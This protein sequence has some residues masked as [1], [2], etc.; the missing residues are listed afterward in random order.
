MDETGQQR[1][2]VWNLPNAL[3]VIRL[4]GSPVLVVLAALQQSAA[5]VALLIVLLLTDW[6]DGRLARWWKQQT[7]LGARLDSFADAALFGALLAGAVWLKGSFLLANIAWIVPA[8]ASYALSTL[9]GLIKFRRWPSYHTRLAKLSNYLVSMG[10]I[11]V[12]ADVTAWLFWISMVSV[13][14]TNIESA[15]IGLVL[16]KRHAD[17]SSIFRALKLRQADTQP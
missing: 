4:F 16:T 13:T 8:L 9:V 2:S 11:L 12:L 6:F 14:V 5:F 15:A 3:C 17:V 1:V 7:A 10:A